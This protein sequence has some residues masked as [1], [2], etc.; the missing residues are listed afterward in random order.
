VIVAI[1]VTQAD[2]DAGGH[3]CGDCPLWLAITRALPG[4]LG[5]CVGQWFVEDRDGIVAALPDEAVEWIAA[6]DAGFPVRPFTFGLDVDE[7]ALT[8]VAP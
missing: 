5:L 8:G 2:I 4:P 7:P 1:E 6:Y 3:S